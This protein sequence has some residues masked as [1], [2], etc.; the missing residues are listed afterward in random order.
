MWEHP[1]PEFVSRDSTEL[2][3][4]QFSGYSFDTSISLL[5]KIAYP[6][7][8][9]NRA[10]DKF[11]QNSGKITHLL[12]KISLRLSGFSLKDLKDSFIPDE[13]FKS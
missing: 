12:G 4:N 7:Y 13:Q 6:E 5:F 3:E 1:W 8:P 2:N 10:L 9:P 11:A